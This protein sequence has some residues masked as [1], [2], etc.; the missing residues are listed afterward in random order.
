MKLSIYSA[1]QQLRTFCFT[2]YRFFLIFIILPFYHLH[3]QLVHRDQA[4]FHLFIHICQTIYIIFI[5]LAKGPVLLFV[6][7][8]GDSTKWAD[9]Q[10][11]DFLVKF[12][13]FFVKFIFDLKVVLLCYIGLFILFIGNSL[14]T[15]VRG[16]RGLVVVVVSVIFD[17]LLWPEKK[18]KLWSCNEDF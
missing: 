14:R 12:F 2:N 4:G 11:F 3:F 1:I 8:F 13:E 5:P 17:F 10:I 7:F 6:N 16:R 18:W 15:C 9:P